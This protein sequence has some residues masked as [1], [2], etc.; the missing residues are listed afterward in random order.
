MCYYQNLTSMII[1]IFY[2]CLILIVA[3]GCKSDIEN[4]GINTEFE[5]A[6]GTAQMVKTLGE[7]YAGI[8][9][10]Q[11]PYHNNFVRANN[12]KSLMESSNASKN[13]KLIAGIRFG[14]ELLMAG[15]NLEA[16]VALEKSLQELKIRG[17]EEK[18]E[19]IVNRL[20][21]ISYMRIGE[22][23][24]C[25]NKNKENSCIFPIQGDGIY[26]L[27]SGPEKAI[28]IY[29]KILEKSPN[30][31]EAIWMLNI[32]YMTLGDYPDKVPAQFR[33]PPS[34]FASN[35]YINP[36]KNI[37]SKVNLNTKGLS[38]G[39]IVEDMDNDGFLD[40][41]A[42]S[43]GIKDQMK[44]FR[45]D[46]KG[47]FIDVTNESGLVG[48]TSGL[49]MMQADYD[50]DG[51]KDILVLRGA[52]YLN[53]GQ[54]PNSLLKNMGDFKF[55]DVT[56]EVGLFSKFPTQ[57]ATWA[58]FNSDGWIDLFIGNE[59]TS[60][61]KAPC[62]LYI[63]HNGRFTNESV[64]SQIASITQ[65]VKG[66]TSGDI[67]NDGDQDLYI[68]V[69]SG[70]NILLRNDS[71]ETGI[72]F[73]NTTINAGVSEP[74]GSFPTWM[75]DYNND[76]NLDIF[77]GSYDMR[78]NDVAGNVAAAY[79]GKGSDVQRSYLYQNNGNGTFTNVA[80]SSGLD[81]P[82]Y[83]MGS[84]YG[85]VDNDGFLDMYLGTG[86]PSFTSV[87]PNKMF[88]NNAGKSFEDV[89]T[90]S[91]LG[92]IQKGHGVSFG[93][94]DNDGDTDIF[95]VLGGAFEGDVFLDALFEN[96]GTEG[97]NFINIECVGSTCNKSA[98]GAKIKVTGIDK[99]GSKNVSYHLVNS[100]GS[101]GASSLAQ[102]I[103][104]G[105][106]INIESVEVFWPNK[107]KSVDKYTNI[108][109]NTF[110]KLTEGST[111]VVYKKITK[112]NFGS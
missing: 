99:S 49:N 105:H 83:I 82:M 111:E 64:S 50:N 94:I 110:I 78:N 4:K 44:V 42:S 70:N 81:E 84:N 6:D 72:K 76:G 88:R 45:N 104:L 112:I 96:P 75:W 19:D 71:D 89:T 98:I 36:F 67:D 66:A 58:D 33:I 34:S 8:D 35:G 17:N 48:L 52:W 15:K 109:P 101:F 77:A 53:N 13:D 65:F 57:A 47:K 87:V 73:V 9:P 95:H 54:I 46:G 62:E 28:S 22:Q 80:K 16:I 102:E 24:N 7:I 79:L 5:P 26:S 103:G 14:Y 30:N 25:L 37:S 21:A 92:H 97:N 10:M 106:A 108:S 107:S 12:F 69:L 38:G 18:N 27:R 59:S 40:I 3:F 85:D 100:G 41:I 90:V 23:E 86:A 32:A 68:S 29:K 43:W 51:L 61:I 63:N 93:D 74:F 39:T 91:R 20:L 56:V 31:Y 1:R 60:A 2:F 55:K 11:V